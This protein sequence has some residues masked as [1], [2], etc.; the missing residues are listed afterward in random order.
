MNR[1]L[2]ILALMLFGIQTLALAVTDVEVPVNIR[3]NN[4]F[5]ESLR[6]NN[7]ARLAFD[8]G[9]YVESTHYSEEAIRFAYLSDE[10]VLLRLK[11]MECDS[12]IAAAQ[13]RLESLSAN[14]ARYPT[15]YSRAQT[16]FSEAR[17][18]RTAE[19]WDD[20]IVAA[21]RVLAALVNVADSLISQQP[22]A[23]QQTP[24]PGGEI[25]HPLPSQYMVR[26]WAVH[27]DC[28][29]NIAGRPWVYN[30]PTQWRR[31]YE[32]NID[33]MPQRNNPDL[34][35]P[36]MILQIPSISGESRLG[37]WEEGREY[38]PLR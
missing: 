28:L 18:L 22:I 38:Q 15:E 10:Y 1:G 16:A 19:R 6:Y 24:G 17:S 5:I 25:V 12:A 9:K 27:G 30:D 2:V 7:L 14:S 37:M 33:R 26:T 29:W 21:S 35:V 4:F 23:Q 13:T 11:M 32:A 20:A 34:I 8:E 31:I 36:G 3:N